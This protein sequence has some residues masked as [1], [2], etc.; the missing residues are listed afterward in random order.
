MRSRS[1]PRYAL[2]LS[3]YRNKAITREDIDLLSSRM[4]YELDEDERQKFAG[5]LNLYVTNKSV[6]LHN[7]S[8]AIEQN[9]PLL[10]LCPEFSYNCGICTED[11]AGIYIGIDMEV[12]LTKN[13]NS[14]LF[15]CNGSR[16]VIRD[17]VYKKPITQTSLPCFIVLEDM[18]KKY[19]GKSLVEGKSLIPIFPA[20]D[21]IQCVHFE[22]QLTVIN[23]N[24]PQ[25][26]PP[27][28]CRVLRYHK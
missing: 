17:I 26:Q 27:T 20:V 5:A 6:H 22:K 28:K 1:D 2:L 14:Q 9:K 25:H 15:L 23:F 12:I 4:D 11:I 16:L 10:Y 24:C 18:K 3:N 19:R 13:L 21:I 7:Q 8:Y